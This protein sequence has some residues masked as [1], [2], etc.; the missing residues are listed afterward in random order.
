MQ[1]IAEYP[2][3]RL[4][5]VRV[6][7]EIVDVGVES[8]VGSWVT[9]RWTVSSRSGR[10]L[11][12]DTLRGDAE[13]ADAFGVLHALRAAASAGRRALLGDPGWRR[14]EPDPDEDVPGCSG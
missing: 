6:A 2:V 13:A 9:L 10:V 11:W 12:R 4:I 8:D 5:R 7:I 1:S 3:A 14:Y